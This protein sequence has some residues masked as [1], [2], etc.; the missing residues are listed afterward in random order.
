MSQQAALSKG[1]FGNKSSEVV[2]VSKI[3]IEADMETHWDKR[4][5]RGDDRGGEGVI[6]ECTWIYFVL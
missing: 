3:D 6:L 2:N 4:E 1:Y 5:R